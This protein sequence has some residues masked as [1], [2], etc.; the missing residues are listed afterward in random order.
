MLARFSWARV[1]IAVVLIGGSLVT[2]SLAGACLDYAG[3]DLFAGCTTSV[4]VVI[5][6]SGSGSGED[7]GSDTEADAGSDAAD[8]CGAPA[9]TQGTESGS[10]S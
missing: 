9:A 3:E 7:T 10:G 8:D 1:R 2:M 4:T 6:G 5:I